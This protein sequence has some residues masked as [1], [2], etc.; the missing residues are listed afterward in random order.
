MP[1]SSISEQK[2]WVYTKV[3]PCWSIGF[4]EAS[5]Q[6]ERKRKLD[7]EINAL[8]HLEWPYSRPINMRFYCHVFARVAGNIF[9]WSSQELWILF[10]SSVVLSLQRSPFFSFLFVKKCHECLCSFCPFT[11]LFLSM[12]L[13]S[14]FSKFTWWVRF[15]NF[16]NFWQEKLFVWPK[17]AF[18]GWGAFRPF[19][20]QPE[21]F[22]STY[23]VGASIFSMRSW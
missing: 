3:A 5:F 16:K 4:P 20:E 22:L 15:L 1:F 2:V 23:I 10:N 17:V 12:L 19:Y 9:C 21:P 8:F 11:W 6:F 14:Y 18:F 13:L 7:P